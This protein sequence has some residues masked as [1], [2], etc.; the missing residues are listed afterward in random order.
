MFSKVSH[1]SLQK[2]TN[3]LTCDSVVF[4]SV[5]TGD[6]GNCFILVTGLGIVYHGDN[7]VLQTGIRRKSTKKQN[8]QKR[9]RG[10]LFGL[11]PNHRAHIG[12]MRIL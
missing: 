2:N 7:S 1:C 11:T 5:D 9:R 8:S 10:E 6:G 12:L 3:W 4:F